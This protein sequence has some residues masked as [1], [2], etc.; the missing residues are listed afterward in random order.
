[1]GE[2]VD[3]TLKRV[4]D[5]RLRNLIFGTEQP[6]EKTITGKIIY[7]MNNI[8]LV[9]F[10]GFF[11][12]WKHRD[13]FD[14]AGGESANTKRIN[15]TFADIYSGNGLSMELI[16]FLL[17]E[18]QLDAVKNPFSPYR[19]YVRENITCSR[20]QQI[21]EIIRVWRISYKHAEQNLEK[22]TTLYT[23]L[24]RSLPILRKLQ[25]DDSAGKMEFTILTEDDDEITE[26]MSYF[27]KLI[28][29]D[30]ESDYYFLH[31]AIKE[32]NVIKLEYMDFSG[33]NTCSGDEN[34]DFTIGVGDFRRLVGYSSSYNPGSAVQ[35]LNI[36]NFKYIRKLAMA[37][38]DVLQKGTKRIIMGTYENNRKYKE[39]FE[40][41][42]IDEL[43]WD[44][45]VVLLMLE[46]GPSDIIE[47]VLKNDANAF[48]DILRNVSVR[49]DL[50]INK[51][52]EKFE[53]L[54]RTEEIYE[55]KQH[56]GF[57][58]NKTL[59]LWRRSA[60]ISL[61]AQFIV[62]V[63][64]DT[65][66][67]N[68]TTNAFYAESLSMKKKKI[69]AS[70]KDGNASEVEV[71]QLLNK[72]FERVFKMLIVF[73][74]GV[75]AYAQKR[76]EMLKKVVDLRRRQSS[77]FLDVLQK[78]CE[79]AFFAAVEEGM[80]QQNRSG[81]SINNSS[82]GV[83]I[84]M[85][86][87]LCADMG[88]KHG[89]FFVQRGDK[90]KLLHSV[91]GRSEICDVSQLRK[92]IS[93]K[94]GELGDDVNGP[95]DLLEFFNKYLKHDDVSVDIPENV[96]KLY[97]DRSLELLKY[98]AFNKDYIKEGKMCHQL[99]Y[100]PIFPYVVRYSEKSENRDKCSVCQY[101]INT[102]GEFDKAMGIKL[103]TEF[104]YKINE[105]YYCIPNAE[106]ST[107]NWWVAPFLISC[108]DFDRIFLKL[109]K[110]DGEGEKESCDI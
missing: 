66:I 22:L 78:D 75:L 104:E 65:D 15:N 93:V 60:E 10:F 71:V 21:A 81:K 26:D 85:F 12:L 74:K 38:A 46:E 91:I 31:R 29:Y 83:L 72:T 19:N 79:Q 32:D 24:I 16:A 44:N 98:L 53:Q 84:G 37:V 33:A 62:S 63:V 5:A 35:N 8:M 58:E 67:D 69:E 40:S 88:V 2:L 11:M 90:G 110:E 45:I 59:N 7:C 102:E 55:E 73:Y 82:L 14:T 20:F 48:D 23:E 106:C 9:S 34:G 94:Q 18:I 28:E 68:V 27:I 99:I 92:I 17:T 97:Y 1:M 87:E 52:T 95:K 108:R 103:L 6:E 57:K 39:I 54:Q 43:N 50:D 36:L 13:D 49:F 56:K 42:N 25:V 51:L 47:E 80:T 41:G 4:K 100:D 101:V 30:F 86:E 89:N 70:R 105:L 64:A 109:S 76:E 77:E 107:K 3:L 61:M 96:V